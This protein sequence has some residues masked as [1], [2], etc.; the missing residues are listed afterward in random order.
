MLDSILIIALFLVGMFIRFVL[1]PM[2]LAFCDDVN[3]LEDC[4][5]NISITQ[6][7]KNYPLNYIRYTYLSFFMKF[8][9]VNMIFPYTTS[10]LLFVFTLIIQFM[11]FKAFQFYRRDQGSVLGEDMT[12]F[13][14]FRES[15]LFIVRSWFIMWCGIENRAYLHSMIIWCTWAPRYVDTYV[16]YYL[17][18]KRTSHHNVIS[19]ILLWMIL[20]S[21]CIQGSTYIGICLTIY[22]AYHLFTTSKLRNLNMTDLLKP[23]HLGS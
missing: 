21:Y 19:Q 10:F 14:I 8:V 3:D 6:S 18:D 22:Y 20:T 9:F 16:K 17:Y 13:M 2:N 23:T 15:V 1:I 12:D 5:D 11:D 7:I 4:G